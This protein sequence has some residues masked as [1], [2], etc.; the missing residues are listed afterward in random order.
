MGENDSWGRLG[1]S[2]PDRESCAGVLRQKWAW[3]I[4]GTARRPGDCS[5][6][7]KG[8][9]GKEL[10]GRKAVSWPGGILLLLI[11]SLVFSLQVQ[12]K[13]L[14]DFRTPWPN[15]V[16]YKREFLCH[17]SQY[18]HISFVFWAKFVLCPSP[19]PPFSFFCLCLHLLSSLLGGRR[20]SWIKVLLTGCL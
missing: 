13:A 11:R 3:T 17:V 2:I 18:L 7:T 19:P 8:E 12:G 20:A 5:V 15:K 16:W 4:Q 10:G 14:D 6:V 1:G 9:R